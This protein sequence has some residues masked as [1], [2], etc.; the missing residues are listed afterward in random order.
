M[1]TAAALTIAEVRHTV[2]LGDIPPE[3]VHTP[4]VFVHR[5]LHV[6]A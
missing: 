4:G 2:E 5:V 3:H 6:A 1:A